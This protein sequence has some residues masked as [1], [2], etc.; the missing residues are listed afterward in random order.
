MKIKI[1]VISLC[2]NDFQ[3]MFLPLMQSVKTLLDKNTDAQPTKVE[4]FIRELIPVFYWTYLGSEW[5]DTKDKQKE[6]ENINK[7]LQKA[8]I[9]FNEQAQQEMRIKNHGGS[10]FLFTN[11][12]EIGSF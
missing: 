8:K 10:Y 2:D 7:Y 6:I 3:Y 11:T 5:T 12:G 1:V 9:L 4:E